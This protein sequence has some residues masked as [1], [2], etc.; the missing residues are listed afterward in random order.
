ML[1]VTGGHGRDHERALPRTASGAVVAAG[2]PAVALA[3][4]VSHGA[5]GSRATGG[6]RPP[7]IAAG[8]DRRRRSELA[9]PLDG[10]EQ[11]LVGRR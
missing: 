7:P 5:D 3:G 10:L 8:R 6:G 1:V 4:G 11:P 2:G 9:Q